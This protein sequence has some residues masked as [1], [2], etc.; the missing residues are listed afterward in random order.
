MASLLTTALG[1]LVATYF[2]LRFLLHLTQDA[3]EPPAIV[4]GI[5]FVSPLIG[6]AR[7]KSGFYT[8]LRYVKSLLVRDTSMQ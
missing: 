7:E 1:G 4:T 8:R 5:P 3:K 6:M 2:F